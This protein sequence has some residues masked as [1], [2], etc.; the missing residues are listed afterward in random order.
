V[1]SESHQGGGEVQDD[2][3]VD[4]VHPLPY[5]VGDSIGAGGRGG[6]ALGK[7]DSD[8]FFGEGRSGGVLCQASPTGEWVLSGEKVVEECVVDRDRVGGIGEGGK[9]GGLSWSDQLFGRPN[10]IWGGFCEEICPVGSLGSFNGFS[11]R[12][13]AGRGGFSQNGP[14]LTP[15]RG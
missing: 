7:G 4:E 2:Q 12:Y 9:P 5:G 3:G 1:V 13:G 10:V 11:L 15:A 6:G 14:A 8:F